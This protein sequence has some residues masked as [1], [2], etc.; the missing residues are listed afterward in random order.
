MEVNA[1]SALPTTLVDALRR[2]A[3][4]KATEAAAGVAAVQ[5]ASPAP[6]FG[7]AL[8][9]ALRAVSASQAQSN[10]LTE[11][12]L[13]DPGSVSLEAA[14]VASQK[15]Q[16]AFQSAL[17]VRNRLVAAYSDIMNMQV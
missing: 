3:A 8:E 17:H 7:G 6:S 11:A 13:R 9:S 14:M 12:F 16:I 4:A 5:P 15:S 10:Q 2:N 1:R